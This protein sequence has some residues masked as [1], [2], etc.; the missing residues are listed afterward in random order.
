MLKVYCYIC[1]KELNEPGA[2][3]FSPPRQDQCLKYH[4]CESCFKGVLLALESMDG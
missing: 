4:I 1:D 3:L 2:I